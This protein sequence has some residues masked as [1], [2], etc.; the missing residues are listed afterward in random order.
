MSQSEWSLQLALFE[1]E[2]ILGETFSLCAYEA[3]HPVL[4]V[5]HGSSASRHRDPI[6]Y[7]KYEML[8]RMTI[9]AQPKPHV[10]GLSRSNGVAFHDDLVRAQE[11]ALMELIERDALLRS[12][13]DGGALRFDYK[14]IGD[15]VLS[16]KDP[17]LWEKNFCFVVARVE[18]AV[19]GYNV[20]FACGF[21]RHEEVPIFY[22]FACAKGSQYDANQ[23]AIA[24]AEQRLAFLWGQDLPKELPEESATPDFHQEYFLYP[25]SHKHIMKWL[26]RGRQKVFQTESEDKS[27]LPEDAQFQVLSVPGAE[28]GV[29][30]KAE[31]PGLLPLKF[32][33]EYNFDGIPHPVC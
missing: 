14:A 31:H 7:A 8:E 26:I 15:W 16:F 18:A 33:S 29:V 13:C 11:S 27:L 32:G 10:P 23:K 17:A 19:P 5:A 2:E 4:G 30:V 1:K 25:G 22:G 12:W 28:A 20:A 6:A 21:P 24:E 9:V 3:T